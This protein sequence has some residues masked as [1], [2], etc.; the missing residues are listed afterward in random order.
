MHIDENTYCNANFI[1][2][3]YNEECTDPNH[4]SD[5]GHPFG[6]IIASQGPKN[7]CLQNFYNM[8]I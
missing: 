8:V 3:A 5:V 6:Y 4:L 2:T 7:N 1:K